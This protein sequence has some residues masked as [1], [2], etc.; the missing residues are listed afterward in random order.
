MCCPDELVAS[1]TAAAVA[2]AKQL[3]DDEIGLLAAVLTQL[4][5]TLA[6]YAEARSRCA[7]QDT[8]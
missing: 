3:T 2:M 6:T 5:D 7:A 8:G 1:V 4:A